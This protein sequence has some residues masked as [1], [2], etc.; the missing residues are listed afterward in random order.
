MPKQEDLS[1]VPE[2][3]LKQQREAERKIKEASEEPALEANENTDLPA[4]AV[5]PPAA[6]E[7]A[8]NVEPAPVA[9][10]ISDGTTND[11]QW[12]HKYS[13]LQGK[14]NKEVGDLKS[15]VVDLKAQMERQDVVIQGL[16][17]QQ[18][19]NT[20]ANVEVEDLN[21]EDFTGW[22]DEMKTMVTTVNKLKSIINDQNQIIAGLKGQAPAQQAQGDNGLQTRVETLESEIN[23]S[24]I[25]SYIKY[26]DDNIKGDWRKLNTNPQFNAWLA[27][28]DPISMQPRKAA[29]T[30]AAQ[31][32]RGS[33]VASIFN[34]YISANG[35][36]AGV[37]IADELPGGEGHG[38]GDIVP[39]VT[40]TKE[41]VAKAQNDFVQGRI[42]EEEFD[43]VYSQYQSTLR[44]QSAQR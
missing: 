25:T 1:N 30:I 3:V 28:V 8:L 2:S 11:G 13:V 35:G 41:D 31:G 4:P 17:S 5:E 15:M 36:N 10:A 14:Y 24:R 42:T 40:V 39:K 34:T 22:G 18:S 12:E 38:G 26:L 44:R 37:N 6:E 19:E 32:L 7:P 21:P 27:I 33:Q 9:P 29:L 16:N 43:K 20:P 23:D